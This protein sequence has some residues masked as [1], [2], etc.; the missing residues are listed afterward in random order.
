MTRHNAVWQ[1]RP[2]AATLRVWLYRGHS[3]R[4]LPM[5]NLTRAASFP[6]AL[7]CL[8]LRAVVLAG[9]GLAVQVSLAWL[10]CASLVFSAGANAQTSGPPHRFETNVLAYEAADKTNPPPPGAILLAGDSQF[11][12]WKTVAE[13][14]PGYTIINRGI[15]SFQMSEPTLLCRPPRR[16]VQTEADRAAGR[17]Q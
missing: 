13:D 17:R 14:L 15:D 10:G 4:L 6:G 12:R 11:Y 7:I 1:R 16:R 8:L 2:A 5:P 3:T 9:K